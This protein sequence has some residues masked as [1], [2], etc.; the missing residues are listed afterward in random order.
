MSTD[1]TEIQL[2]TIEYNLF[3]Y[4]LQYFTDSWKI[5][6]EPGQPIGIDSLSN[7]VELTWDPPEKGLKYVDS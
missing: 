6:S 3:S 7:S 5:P 4:A 1:A 2:S